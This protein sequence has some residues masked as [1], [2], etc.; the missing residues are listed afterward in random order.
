MQPSRSSARYFLEGFVDE[1][2]QEAGDQVSVGAEDDEPSKFKTPEDYLNEGPS[3]AK[4]EEVKDH[5]IETSQAK[6]RV[7]TP[8]A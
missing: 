3:P 6:K 1:P 7:S 8:Y 4:I 2:P 5:L